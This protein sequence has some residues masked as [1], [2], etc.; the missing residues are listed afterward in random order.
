VYDA[1]LVLHLLAAAVWVGGTVA[2]TFAG[3]PVIRQLPPEQRGSALRALGRRWRPL[4]WG[5]LAVLVVT[6]LLLARDWNAYD[7][8][9][10]F[11]TEFG[12]KLVAKSILVAAL[13]ALTVVHDLVLGPR[14]ARQLRAGEP[15]TARPPLVLVGRAALVATIAIPV[16]GVLLG[17]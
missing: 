12:A 13:V 17:R 16:L 14:L 9:V 11:D 7:P 3:V 8:D 6:G 1:L 15:P 5:S 4:G 2:L 10:L